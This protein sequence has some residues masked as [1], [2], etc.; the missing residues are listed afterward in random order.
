MGIERNSLWVFLV[1]GGFHSVIE[2]IIA[3]TGVRKIENARILNRSISFPLPALIVGFFEGGIISLA[4]FHFA[5]A[6]TYYDSFSIWL[7]NCF[8]IIFGLLTLIGSVI[9]RKQRDSNP[10]HLQITRRKLF[11]PGSVCLL[12]IFFLI[13][14]GYLLFNWSISP[15]A[16]KSLLY[17]FTGVVI[18]LAVMIIPLHCLGIRFIEIRTTDGYVRA[19]PFEQIAIMYPFNTILEAGWFVCNWVLIH[20][21][22]L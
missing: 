13:A 1:T 7:F 22:K 5:R 9:I 15:Q 3:L 2:A 20:A 11:T 10:T 19:S 18:F 17:F 16:W 12:L 8:C 6:I 14:C 4:A 21:L